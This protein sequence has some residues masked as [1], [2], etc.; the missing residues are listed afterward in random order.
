MR[1]AVKI[2]VA[3]PVRV[4][5]TFRRYVGRGGEQVNVVL[6]LDIL[7]PNANRLVFA[8]Q[9]IGVSWRELEQFVPEESAILFLI[10]RLAA[11]PAVG[12]SP[13]NLRDA[14]IADAYCEMNLGEAYN[15]AD[16]RADNYR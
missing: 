9:Q 4:P 1:L 8:R 12:V 2:L 10:D 14:A 5:Q 3:W 6:V 13:L 11:D 15:A 16:G 7:D